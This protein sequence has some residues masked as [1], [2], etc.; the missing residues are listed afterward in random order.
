MKIVWVAQPKTL[1]ERHRRALGGSPE[2]QGLRSKE[3]PIRLKE[4]LRISTGRRVKVRPQVASETAAAARQTAS[5]FESSVREVIETRPYTAVLIALGIGWL[6]G[7]D[8][9]SSLSPAG[10]FH[11]R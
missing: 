7:R 8:A 6:L 3:L 5:S 4:P 9:P 1:P 11:P 2:T 10:D